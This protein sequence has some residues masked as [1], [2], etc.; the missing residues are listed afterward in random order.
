MYFTA[1]FKI[2]IMCDRE[3]KTLGGFLRCSNFTDAV[4]QLED[5][6]GEDLLA[7]DIELYEDIIVEINPEI[8]AE[9][10]KENGLF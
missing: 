5:Y 7:V 6:Y 8:A 2:R 4:K 9:I 3:I 10:A 1:Y